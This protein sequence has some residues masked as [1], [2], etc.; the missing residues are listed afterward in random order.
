MAINFPSSPSLN[1]IYSYGGNTWQW[2]GESWVSLG[3]LPDLGPQ[4]PQGPSGPSG[5][6]APVSNS[7]STV[8]T[9]NGVANVYTLS[10]NVSNINNILITIDGVVISPSEYTVTSNNVLTIKY[11]PANNSIIEARTLAGVGAITGT[12]ITLDSFIGNGSNTNFTI[13]TT[14]VN[15]NQLMIFVD[16]VQQRANDFSLSGN[17]VTFT[18]GAPDA[19][20]V[21]D[22]YS[23]IAYSGA[24]GA[25]GATGPQGP[26][27][28][29]GSNGAN[30]P[31]GPQG[32]AGSNGAT[33]PQGPQG[34]SGPTGAVTDYIHPFL[35]IGI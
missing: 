26:Q 10:S 17:V 24:N 28:P 23:Y 32:P 27:G 16:S 21:I 14:P 5:P 4:G 29:A 1:D 8:I 31:Q 18:T 9:A 22:I 11:T 15:Q 33:G 19:N 3:Q 34:P 2:D 12:P 25:D 7:V 20:A 13:S 6:M 35:F 30:G